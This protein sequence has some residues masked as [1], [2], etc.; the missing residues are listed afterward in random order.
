MSQA[1]LYDVDGYEEQNRLKVDAPHIG[2]QCAKVGHDG[3][4]NLTYQLDGGMPAAR[5]N[6]A[7]DDHGDEYKKGQ[8]GE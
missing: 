8:I 1:D 5:R 4:S 7:D 3:F 6:P 2:Q